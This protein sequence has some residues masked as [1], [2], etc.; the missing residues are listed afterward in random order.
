M[1]NSDKKLTAELANQWRLKE[2]EKIAAQIPPDNEVEVSKER[3]EKD[4]E[5]EKQKLTDN[6]EQDCRKMV[7]FNVNILIM[8][9][10]VISML[11]LYHFISLEV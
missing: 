1:E 6:E 2:K 11:I 3:K 10:V 4:E 8:M 7:A 5:K 9:L